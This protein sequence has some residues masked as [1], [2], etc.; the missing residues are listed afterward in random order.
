MAE[1]TAT[2]LGNIPGSTGV[3]KSSEIDTL[4][5]AIEEKYDGKLSSAMHYKGTVATVDALPTNAETGDMYNVTATDDNYAFNGTSWDKM[6]PTF[7]LP[8]YLADSALEAK[9]VQ[10]ANLDTAVAG[11]G[12]AKTAD[13]NTELAKKQNNLS[14]E[15]IAACDSG[16]TSTLRASY[17]A[18]LANG[19][20]HVTT[21]DKA[22]WSGKQDALS[23][24]QLAAC[25]SGITKAKVEKYDAFDA[26][27]QDTLSDAQMLAVDSGITA[28]KLANIEAGVAAAQVAADLDTDVAALNYVKVGVTNAL[29]ERCTAVE[30]RC[31]TAEGDIDALETRCGTIEGAATTLKG[32]VDA[33]AAVTM[34]GKDDVTIYG[35]YDTVK[36]IVD[37]AAAPA[38]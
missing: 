1:I 21:E 13:V 35:L 26:G 14:T 22:E 31:T 15:Q 5:K 18:H 12:Y 23:V 30:G 8:D 24:A 36:A 33:V 2:V 3:Y 9:Y 4:L 29:A 6:A 34:P 27:K 11:H 20:I 25:D 19:D 16:I 32:R 28:T 7:V 10:I 37:A 17:D 38:A